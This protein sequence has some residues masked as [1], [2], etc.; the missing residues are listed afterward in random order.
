MKKVIF[1][2]VCLLGFATANFAQTPTTVKPEV[3]A[4]R[5]KNIDQLVAACKTAGLDEKQ[6]EKAKTIIENLYKKQD[7]IQNDATLTPE[8]K[9]QKL[10]DANGEKDWK[11]KNAM[12]DKYM[13]YVE[14]RK[15]M[16]AEAAEKKQ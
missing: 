2:F 1:I 10:K 3:A 16:A 8:E 7:E 9:K 6:T 12:G 14:A 5:A 4:Q 15:K 13:A 11:I